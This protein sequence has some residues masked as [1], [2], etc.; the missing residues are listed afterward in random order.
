[1]QLNS[2][3]VINFTPLPSKR[4]VSV[5]ILYN[6]TQIQKYFT[7]A[8][9]VLLVTNIMSGSRDSY[10]IVIIHNGQIAFQWWIKKKSKCSKQV[11]KPY[12]AHLKTCAMKIFWRSKFAK[13]LYFGKVQYESWMKSFTLSIPRKSPVFLDNC[14]GQYREADSQLLDIK[15]IQRRQFLLV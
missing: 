11:S 4:V 12:L 15:T 3:W 7:L 9:L 1:M 14:S 10:I 2:S 6:F 8:L 13:H 5:L